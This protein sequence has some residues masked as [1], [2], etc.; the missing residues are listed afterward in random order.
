MD[1]GRA[2]RLA[3]AYV[4][5]SAQGVG[6]QPGSLWSRGADSPYL[7]FSRSYGAH[8]IPFGLHGSLTIVLSG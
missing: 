2:G 8:G 6:L 1:S 5:A 4:A 7:I 3:A